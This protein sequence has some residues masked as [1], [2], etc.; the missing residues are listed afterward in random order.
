MSRAR[1]ETGPILAALGMLVVA[2]AAGALLR[3]HWRLAG[4]LRA[5]PERPVPES[6][7]VLLWGTIAVV[8]HLIRRLI[9]SRGWRWAA[10]YVP[11]AGG[12]IELA[13]LFFVWLSVLEA[14][15]TSRSL[16]REP[17]LWIGLG[18]ALLPPTVQLAVYIARWRP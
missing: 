17:R 12:L 4:L 18:L 9:E 11:V 5:Q 1:F 7:K 3:R 2:V 10:V 6:G 16:R 15:R 13:V 14:R 8:L